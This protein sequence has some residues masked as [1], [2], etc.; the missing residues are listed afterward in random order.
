MAANEIVLS[1]NIENPSSSSVYDHCRV[2]PNNPFV[3]FPKEDIDQT[4]PSRFEHIVACDPLRIA[5]KT[6]EQTANYSSLNKAA[7]RI[8]NAILSR[9]GKDNEPVA[10]VVENDAAT[11]AA[12]LG[13][14]K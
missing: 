10:V 14:L 13:V 3:R 8:A 6:S 7:N 1:A 9:S 12:I 2:A 5:V 4:I 11:I